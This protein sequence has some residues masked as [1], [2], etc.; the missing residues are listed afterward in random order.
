[1][2]GEIVEFYGK[3]HIFYPAAVRNLNLDWGEVQDAVNPRQDEQVGNN[4]GVPWRD[5]NNPNFNIPLLDNLVEPVSML[6]NEAVGQRPAYL[7]GIHIKGH[8]KPVVV[9]EEVAMAN[10]RRTQ[11]TH[12]EK[13]HFPLVV[14]AENVLDFRVKALGLVANTTN[15]KFPKVGQVLT[16]LR[17]VHPTLFS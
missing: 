4:L 11:V 13:G 8:N 3:I 10:E 2:V 15:A 9:L 12:T 7:L 6:D 5:G 17:W 1:M 14:K 16:D